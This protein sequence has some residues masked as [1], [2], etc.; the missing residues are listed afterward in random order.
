[1]PAGASQY[2]IR[3][4]SEM[5]C[6]RIFAPRAEFFD[7]AG[8]IK[9][10]V[11]YGDFTFRGN[12]LSAILRGHS[13]E[14]YL[15]VASDPQIAGQSVSRISEDRLSATCSGALALYTGSEN[16]THQ[17]FSHEGKVTVSVEALPT[18]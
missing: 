1:L 7:A 9:R 8:N 4:E 10:T 17:T 2:L 3:I 5:S 16:T 15:V 6:D 12:V 13:D 11:A 14:T 18:K